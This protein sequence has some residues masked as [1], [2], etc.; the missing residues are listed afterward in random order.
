MANAP[1]TLTSLCAFPTLNEDKTP[2]NN[3]E[4]AIYF[5]NNAGFLGTAQKK[6]IRNC[7]LPRGA[8]PNGW[9]PELYHNNNKPC[10]FGGMACILFS[11]DLPQF[12]L[13]IR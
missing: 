3:T 8:H 2:L 5:P 1:A 12:F 9:A 10:P 7:N 11:R 4:I 13:R 6:G